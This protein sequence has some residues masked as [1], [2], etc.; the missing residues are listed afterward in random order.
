M[1]LVRQSG[2]GSLPSAIMI[3]FSARIP[4]VEGLERSFGKALNKPASANRV[5][6]TSTFVFILGESPCATFARCEVYDGIT[7]AKLKIL[8]I[9]RHSAPLVEALTSFAVKGL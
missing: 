1:R 7:C 3:V 8:E 9:C 4:A 5:S 2:M 6:K